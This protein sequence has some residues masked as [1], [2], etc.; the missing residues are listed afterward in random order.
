MVIFEHCSMEMADDAQRKWQN[1]HK[2]VVVLTLGLF[3]RAQRPA[4][5]F[6]V[7]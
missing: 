1:K 5:L 3:G 7:L 4:V 2:T 6:G